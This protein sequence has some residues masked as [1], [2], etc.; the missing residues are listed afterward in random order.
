MT[1]ETIHGVLAAVDGSPRA[2]G[3]LAR[4]RDLAARYQTDIYLLRVIDVPPEFPAA[5]AGSQADTLGPHLA[6]IAEKELAALAKETFATP[7]KVI[8]RAGQPWRVILEVAEELAVGVIVIGSHGYY[9]LDHLIGTTAGKVANVSPRDVY[10]VHDFPLS[11]EVR[12]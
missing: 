5:A 6:A 11:R 12:L 3:V 1:E 2:P 8:V 4:A 10:I 7:A 9:G